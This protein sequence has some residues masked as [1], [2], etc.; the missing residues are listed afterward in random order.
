M[1]KTHLLSVEAGWNGNVSQLVENR[2][3]LPVHRVMAAQQLVRVRVVELH[4]EAAGGVAVAG[5]VDQMDSVIGGGVVAPAARVLAHRAVRH[6]H[7]VTHGEVG[8][9]CVHTLG[10][11]GARR[12]GCDVILAG[13]ALGLP[14]D[15]DEVL[16]GGGRLGR[17]LLR[18]EKKFAHRGPSISQW[19][20]ECSSMAG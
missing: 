6:R 11:R 13:V 18:G 4:G 8:A 16:V 2:V 12:A 10:W 20:D 9:D 17:V 3:A 7:H 1:A 15:A 19:R 5:R 14:V